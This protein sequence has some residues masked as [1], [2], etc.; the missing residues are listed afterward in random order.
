MRRG[1]CHLL[2]L[3]TE[4]HFSSHVLFIETPSGVSDWRRK[5]EEQCYLCTPSHLMLLVPTGASYPVTC[6]DI[7][8]ATCPRFFFPSSILSTKRTV[9]LFSIPDRLQPLTRPNG[10]NGPFRPPR[11]PPSGLGGLSLC[12]RPQPRRAGRESRRGFV[13]RHTRQVLWQV[14]GSQRRSRRRH[15]ES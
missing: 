9:S 13:S 11:A 10:T 3:S 5:A 4:V 1:V 12:R 14:P 8:H 2:S 15:S 7:R 6:R